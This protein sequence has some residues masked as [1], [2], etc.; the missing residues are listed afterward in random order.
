MCFLFIGLD[1]SVRHIE[2]KTKIC[3]CVSVKNKIKL[4]SIMRSLTNIYVFTCAF[5]FTL[6]NNI[7]PTVED[8]FIANYLSSLLTSI[9]KI[10]PVRTEVLDLSHNR[11]SGLSV[12]EFIY[13]SNLQ[14]LNLSHNLIMVLDFGVFIFNENLE[15]L[16]LSH[17][18]ISKVCCLTLAYLRHLDLSFNK[19][20]ALPICQEFGNM[21]HLEYLGLSAMMIRRSDF[22][23]YETFA[24]A[25]CLPDLGK[26]F[27]V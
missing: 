1:S 27:S 4:D 21:F 2:Q 9:P 3:F 26:L 7:Q 23:L 13:L 8:E 19:F 16:D 12:S 15:H 25:H 17:N 11:I 6:W 14:V 5:T 18:Y 24:A 22:R 10:I 20:I